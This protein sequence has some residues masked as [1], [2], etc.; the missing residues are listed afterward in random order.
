MEKKLKVAIIG[1][2]FA[3]INAAKAISKNPQIELTLIDKNNYHTFQ[4][5]LYQVAIGGLEPS[6]IAY[7]IR[8]I[9]RKTKVKFLMT[10]VEQLNTQ[11][12]QIITDKGSLHYDYLVLATGSNNNFFNFTPI[13]HELLP[14]KS[15]GEAL[16]IRSNLYQNLEQI[17]FV[18]EGQRKGLMNIAVVGGGP[19]GVEVA[20]SL[21]EMRKKVLPKDFPDYDFSQMHIYLFEA[22]D[23][24][25]AS[26]SARSAEKA[27]HYLEKLGV[28]VFLQARVKHYD[29][30]SILLEDGTAYQANTVIWTAGVK[31]ETI[32][33]A[34]AD[35]LLPGNRLSVNEFNQVVGHPNIFAIGDVAAHISPA[36]PKGLPML[37]QVAIQQGKHLAGNLKRLASNQPLVPFKYKDMGT[38]ATIGRNK[39]VVD[40]PRISFQGIFA[41]FLWMFVHLLA[42]AGFRNR[43]ITLIDWAINYVSYDR[44]LGAIIRRYSKNGANMPVQNLAAHEVK[45]TKA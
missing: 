39:A 14:L 23:K 36:S 6:N 5:L 19:A 32:A 40:L 26:M 37:A 41:W 8:R 29:G 21:A 3:G 10:V 27:R 12:Q 25:L 7:P 38:M 16:D 11:E 42:L 43:V 24:V 20:G 2:G 18:D 35:A 33:G 22:A 45:N 34:P 1:A 17:N 13:K 9:F 15:V 28:S 44:P 31:G 4:P 30:N